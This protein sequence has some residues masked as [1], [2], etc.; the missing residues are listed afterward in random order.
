MEVLAM[1]RKKNRL[2]L[3]LLACVIPELELFHEV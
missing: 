2:I 1:A 3:S